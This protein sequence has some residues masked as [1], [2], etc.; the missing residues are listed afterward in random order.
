MKIRK[1]LCLTLAVMMLLSCM[2]ACGTTTEEPAETKGNT[3]STGNVESEA[4]TNDGLADALERMKDADWGGEA[5]G[6]MYVN[7]IAG[8]TEE[9]EA[10]KE[11]GDQTSSAII[12]DAVYERNCLFEDMCNLTLELLPTPNPSIMSAMTN[13]VATQTG[14]FVLTTAP[15][16]ITASMATNALLYNYLD[17]YIDYE[18]VWWDQGTLEFALDGRVFFMNGAHNI[19]DDDVT[20]VMM[21]NKQLQEDNKIENPYT[22]VQNSEWTL[23]YFNTIIQNVSS[24]TGDPAWDEND[25]YGFT[26]PSSIGNTFFYGAGLQYVVNGRDMDRPELVLKDSNLEKA[27]QVLDL[28]CSIIHDN[29]STYL[30][31]SGNEI[32]SRNMFVDGRSMFYVEAASYLRSLN[33][34]MEGDYGV[35]P[36]PKWDKAQEHYLTWTHDIGSTLSMPT[37][38][39]KSAEK[40]EGVLEAYVVLSYQYVKPAYYDTM[41]TVKNVRDPQ[42]SEMLD[43]IFQHRTYD[44][45]MYF[46]DLGMNSLFSTCVATNKDNFASSFKSVSQ[47]FD[48]KLNT[49]LGNLEKQGS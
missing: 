20:M 11:A 3:A 24:N 34:T 36:I 48:R 16:S 28:A 2:V 44:M 39:L 30:A 19:V 33:Q 7:D 1:I 29:N 22:T 47:R 5:F 18:Q 17:L 6:V 42:S 49:I 27:T 10:E 45:G 13:E 26:T 14:D 43:L 38:V 40:L 8:Y 9:I 21:F 12:N 31:T 4:Q 25:T 15:T 41:L 23:N 32:L 35:V 46:A 37:S